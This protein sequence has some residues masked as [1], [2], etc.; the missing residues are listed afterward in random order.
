MIINITNEIV[1]T[2]MK[3]RRERAIGLQKQFTVHWPVCGDLTFEN[4]RVVSKIQT[5]SVP[6]LTV[7]IAF[8]NYFYPTIYLE[9][10]FKSASYETLLKPFLENTSEDSEHAQM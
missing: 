6:F 3:I 4:G 5:P 7:L 8:E 10:C 2:G 1:F 9:I